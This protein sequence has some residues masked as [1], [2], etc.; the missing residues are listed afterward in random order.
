MGRIILLSLVALPF[1]EIAV[2][3]WIGGMIGILP[4]LAAI[5]ATAVLGVALVRRQGLGL[6]IDSRTLMARNQMPARQLFEGMLVALGGFLL[7]VPGFVTDLL[8][9]ALLIPPVRAAL[10]AL[11]SRHMVVVTSYRGPGGE[12]PRAIDLDPDSYR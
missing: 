2:F 6:L 4:T 5:V 8:G 3:I 12:G 7:I 9:L 1:I 10:F 11:L